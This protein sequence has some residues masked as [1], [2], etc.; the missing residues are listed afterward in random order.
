ML[1]HK[2]NTDRDVA[3]PQSRSARFMRSYQASARA[4][5]A[6][7]TLQK[8]IANSSTTDRHVVRHHV[9]LSELNAEKI[10]LSNSTVFSD[11]RELLNSN[12][13]AQPW[14]PTLST[15]ICSIHSNQKLSL[16]CLSSNLSAF[17][18]KSFQNTTPLAKQKISFPFFHVN[19]LFLYIIYTCFCKP[20][21]VAPRDA[22]FTRSSDV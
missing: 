10:L 12:H 6:R 11:R 8:L 15:A 7:W 13:S 4:T 21:C 3:R 2:S 22:R 14:P 5:G 18:Y 19:S 17:F 9:Q 16:L 1:L 20:S